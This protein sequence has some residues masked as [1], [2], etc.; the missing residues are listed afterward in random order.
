[1]KLSINTMR[2]DAGARL[3]INAA[4]DR[5][6]IDDLPRGSLSEGVADAIILIYR[7]KVEAA[8]RRAGIEVEAGG[9]LNVD[10]LRELVSKRAG[11]E[12]DSWGADDVREGV[13]KAINS[14]VSEAI[15]VEIDLS[16]DVRSQ[17][18]AA[19]VEA[20]AGNR[21]N[22]LVSQSVIDR[23][24]DVA[25]LRALGLDKSRKRLIDNRAS[26]KKYRANHR[27]I[28]VSK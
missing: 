18:V 11:I 6:R 16:G 17:L 7:D 24:R 22:K 8:L 28:W 21:P 12:L 20:V 3:A 14:R 1:M 4:I 13:A 9:V 19:A 27:Q 10:T 23:L 15:G 2:A 25:A 26:A 5:E